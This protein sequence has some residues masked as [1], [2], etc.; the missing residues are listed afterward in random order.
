KTKRHRPPTRISISRVSTLK[1]S[2]PNHI[3]TCCGSVQTLNTSSRGA[4]MTR[5]R[6]IS[7]S[8]SHESRG[9][10]LPALSFATLFLRCLQSEDIGLHPIEPRFPDRSARAQPLLGLRDRFGR[11]AARPRSANLL[12][13]DEPARLEHLHVLDDRRQRRVERRSELAH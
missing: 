10:L 1:P 6:T 4:A 13:R 11:D 7:R 12:G 3:G 9:E 2:G 8:C 5:E